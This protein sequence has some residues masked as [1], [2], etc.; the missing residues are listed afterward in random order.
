MRPDLE[1]LA[2]GWADFF[3]KN[4]AAVAAKLK[5]ELDRDPT[6]IELFSAVSQK[7]DALDTDP[8]E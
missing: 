6:E 4:A 1:A 2:A 7:W 3:E 8:E 5:R